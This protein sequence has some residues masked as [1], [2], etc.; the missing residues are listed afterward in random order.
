MWLVGCSDLRHCEEISQFLQS[1]KILHLFSSA[2]G[3]YTPFLSHNPFVPLLIQSE[4]DIWLDCR[5]LIGSSYFSRFLIE[6][7]THSQTDWW[8][9]QVIKDPSLIHFT[10]IVWILPIWTVVFLG[11]KQQRDYW[12]LPFNKKVQK[13]TESLLGEFRS[14]QNWNS[15][16]NYLRKQNTPIPVW[17]IHSGVM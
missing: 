8:G 14:S 5:A 2:S 9:G 16:I 13:L 12:F 15:F 3:F 4:R 11:V 17:A 10:N 6:S 1:R 7:Y